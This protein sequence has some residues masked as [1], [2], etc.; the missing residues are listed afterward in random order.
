MTVRSSL[1]DRNMRE[2]AS[3]VPATMPSTVVSAATDR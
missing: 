2:P 3:T 1:G